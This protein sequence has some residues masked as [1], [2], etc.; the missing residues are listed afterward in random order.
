MWL[1]LC[2]LSGCLSVRELAPPHPFSVWESGN[3]EP[4]GLL[5]QG[6]L[7]Q[8]FYFNE[9]RADGHISFHEESGRVVIRGKR[10]SDE[11][12]PAQPAVRVAIKLS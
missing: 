1:S 6:C 4:H 2:L 11:R 10:G 9:E 5:F 7:H 12:E 3:Q 8:T